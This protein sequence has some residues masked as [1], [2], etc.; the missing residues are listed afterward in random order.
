MLPI[1]VVL[2]HWS[3]AS[4]P[5]VDFRWERE[6]RVVGDF[7]FTIDD[8]AF[9]LC[10]SHEIPYFEKITNNHFPFIDP[11]NTIAAV[12]AKLRA[13]MRLTNLV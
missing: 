6:W 9:G 5:E 8:I 13:N 12:K 1:S 2:C 11:T 4:A 10:R 3:K 7:D